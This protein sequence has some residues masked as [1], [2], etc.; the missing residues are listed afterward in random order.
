MNKLAFAAAILVAVSAFLIQQAAARPSMEIVSVSR[1][2]DGDTFEIEGGGIVRILGINT[3]E[4]RQPL[5]GNA[6]AFLKSLIEGK[7]VTLEKDIAEMDKYG[8][9]LRYVFIGGA[10]VGEEIIKKGLANA[11]I[12]PPNGKYSTRLKEAEQYARENK[13]G[14]W[15]T[16]ENY[17]GCIS[18]SD[19]SWDA[20]GNDI[21]NLND[22]YLSLVNSCSAAADMANWTLKNSGTKIYRFE[23]FFLA[24]NQSVKVHSGCGADAGKDLFWCS[25]K[26]IWNNNGD[27][28]YL[29]DSNGFLVLSYSY[30]GKG[31]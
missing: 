29:R 20:K 22:E 23:R 6:S 18:V 31:K 11:F 19:F 8:R 26:P 13:I 17:A 4:K 16:D 28:L 10:F 21:E 12:I 9:H 24:P 1:V 30:E 25:K 5:Y 14:L 7:N 2:I 15:E 3:P 27:A